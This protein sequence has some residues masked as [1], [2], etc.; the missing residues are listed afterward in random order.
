[1]GEA[2]PTAG[3][4]PGAGALGV[5]FGGSRSAS[6]EAYLASSS[7][8]V[9]IAGLLTTA[10][11]VV[12]F[13][14]VR[15]HMPDPHALRALLAAPVVASAF[16]GLYACLQ[17][18]NLDPIPWSNTSDF[19]EW[20][21]PF[22][23]LGHPSHLGGYLA[24]TL[25]LTLAF[26]F[27]GARQGKR[28]SLAFLGLFLLAELAALTLSLARGGWIGAVLGLAVFV[29]LTFREGPRLMRRGLIASAAL[30]AG[31]AALAFTTASG[32]QLFGG[33]LERSLRFRESPRGYLWT[34]LAAQQ[35]AQSENRGLA[36]SPVEN[37]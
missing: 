15:S 28:W 3:D 17:A 22:A 32:R 20:S 11:L 2:G 25:P 14:A 1:V 6:V 21:R 24:M 29:T 5:T 10:A 27:R 30:R 12:F 23:T 31:A 9:T 16:L 33:V 13:F 7:A 26:L 34:A 8:Y 36:G 18:V 35:D 4:L 37:R 19:A